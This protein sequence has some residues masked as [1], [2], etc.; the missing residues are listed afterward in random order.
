MRI[1]ICGAG[2][3]GCVVAGRLARDS[4]NEVVLLEAGP[5][6]RPGSWP[7]ALRH[8]HR[9]VTESHDWGYLADTEYSATGQHVP[10]G[11]V[12]GGS[13]ATNGSVALRGRPEDYQRWGGAVDGYDWNSWLPWFRLIENDREF[14]STPFHGSAGPISISRHP[15][16]WL[17]L[18]E[19]FAEAAVNAGHDW[20]ADHNLA[21][22][23]GVGPVPLSMVDGQ[24]QTPADHYL[25]PALARE[26]LELRTGVLVDRIRFRGG[27]ATGV[28][29]VDARGAADLVDADAVILALGTYATPA[30]LLRSGIGPVAELERHGVPIVES[31]PGVGANLQD[32]AKISCRFGL[33]IPAPAEGNPWYQCLLTGVTEVNG[34]RRYYQV[35]PYS[36]YLEGDRS[37]TDLNVQICD[38]RAQRGSVRLRGRDP[39]APPRIELDWLPGASDQAAA[40]AAVGC[41]SDIA[42]TAPL[43]RIVTP[44]EEMV[45]PHRFPYPVRSFH[46]PVGT[47]RMGKDGISDAVVD[48]RGKVWGLDRLWIMD[49]SV[50]PYLPSAN[51]HLT[52]IAL[53]ERLAASFPPAG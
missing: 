45:E 43:D 10:R 22:A 17:Q 2:T 42:R 15:R 21:G 37:V 52:V 33:E 23:L 9:I 46:H 31:L 12:V 3:A 38:A 8:G 40:V 7:E 32:H 4:R 53:A 41:L 34:E 5:H 26:N 11:R 51:V 28:A 35:L 49:A 25:D 39:A 48:G 13:S 29:I 14:G 20:V 24:R 18:Q 47:C 6:Y 30:V 16:P 1:V 19:Y 27:R 44:G 50:I 36:G